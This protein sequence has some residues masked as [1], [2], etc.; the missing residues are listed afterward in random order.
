MPLKLPI[1]RSKVLATDTELNAINA[2]IAA[3][4]R[5]RPSDDGS[6]MLA[7]HVILIQQFAASHGLTTK[8][9]FWAIDS[10]TGEFFCLD[11]VDDNDPAE[12]TK[13]DAV[14]AIA[15]NSLSTSMQV[16]TVG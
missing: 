6:S 2:S 10:K 7:K 11:P 1:V 3:F 12:K 15:A 5:L 9:G 16:K 8:N 13:A 4:R 14:R